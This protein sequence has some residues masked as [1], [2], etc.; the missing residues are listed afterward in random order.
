[1]LPEP[2]AT[3]A[4]TGSPLVVMLPRNADRSR[5]KHDGL[6]RAVEAVRHAR[7]ER[8]A[9]VRGAEQGLLGQHSDACLVHEAWE[10]ADVAG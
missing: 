5:A 3:A 6:R 10:R 8:G 9:G 2:M 7:R 1:M 4:G